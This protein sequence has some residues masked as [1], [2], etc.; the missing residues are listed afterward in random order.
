MPVPHVVDGLDGRVI[1]TD[2]AVVLLGDLDLVELHVE[3]VGEQHRPVEG[4]AF[5]DKVCQL[6]HPTSLTLRGSL[7]ESGACP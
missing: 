2:R 4:L 1:A 5:A 3:G 7:V 6:P